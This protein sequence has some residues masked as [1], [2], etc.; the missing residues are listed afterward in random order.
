MGRVKVFEDRNCVICNST[1]QVNIKSKRSSEKKTCSKNCSSKLGSLTGQSKV[2]CRICN[3]VIYTNK[4]HALSSHGV[5]CSNECRKKR[6]ELKCV[7]CD[8][9]FYSDKNVTK[10][11]SQKCVTEAARAKLV[12]IE[13]YSC[14]KKFR[15]PSFT[16]PEGKR[17][18]CSTRCCNRQ[19]SIENPNRYGS[20]WSTIRRKRLEIDDYT[21]QKC[22]KRTFEKYALNVHHIIPIEEF[23]NLDEANRLDNLQ[24]LCYECH[25]EHHGRSL[26]KN[27]DG[28]LYI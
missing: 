19:F 1:F 17:I 11:C 13:C 10:H 21:C 5:Y 18:F 25:M 27:E 2:N 7:I 9:K 12:D 3:K 23:D 14:K 6:Y 20:R 15:R 8:R 24:T 28:I 26:V 4:T 16:I 22:N